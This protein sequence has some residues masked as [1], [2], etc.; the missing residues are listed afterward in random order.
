M[1]W[2]I[3]NIV[4][5]VK[6][7]KQCAK[8]LFK[9]QEDGEE[10]WYEIKEVTYEG[11]LTFN[12]DHGEFMDYISSPHIQEVLLKHK[13]KGDIC[14]GSLEGDNFGEF[15]G[16]RFDGKGRIETLEGKL[17]WYEKK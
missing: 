10:I 13:V 1:G 3:A 16:Y 5:E 6:I 17:Q 11:K 4:N 15:W 8:D 12:S 7:S 14:F 9:A 2:S